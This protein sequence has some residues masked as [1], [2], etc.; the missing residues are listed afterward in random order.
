MKR[1]LAI[2]VVMLFALPV[3]S[4]SP[5]Q[6]T[7]PERKSVTMG[8]LEGGG[9]LIGM[10]IEGLLYNG[11]GVQ[12]GAGFVGFGGGLNIHFKPEIRS[13]FI[14]LQY[15][16]QGFSSS[17]TQSVLGPAFVFRGKKWL[18]AQLGFGF[19]LEKGPAWPS[20]M[21]QPDLM[22]TYAIGAYIPF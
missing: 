7:R 22:L 13:S 6:G 16:H 8:F 20:S 4:Q 1:N 2:L 15:W 9:S 10:D 21:N 11:F 5:D 14:S 12:A 3:F 19:A 17:Y 18:T